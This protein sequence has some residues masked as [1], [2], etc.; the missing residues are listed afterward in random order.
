MI[1]NYLVTYT[2]RRADGTETDIHYAIAHGK[3]SVQALV[4]FFEYSP[5]TRLEFKSITEVNK[6]YL[7]NVITTIP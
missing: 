3:T 7:A 2:V 1:K 5:Q 6:E 4:R